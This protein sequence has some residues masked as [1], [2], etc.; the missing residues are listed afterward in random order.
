M[1]VNRVAHA[2]S[3]NLIVCFGNHFAAILNVLVCKNNEYMNFGEMARHR[4]PPPD[5][6]D[7][8]YVQNYAI[9]DDLGHKTLPIG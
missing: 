5:N 8:G 4:G 6:F 2:N 7:L 3:I 9:L 1:T